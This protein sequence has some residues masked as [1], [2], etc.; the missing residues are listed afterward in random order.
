MEAIGPN[1]HGDPF[2]GHEHTLYD[3]SPGHVYAKSKRMVE[4]LVMKANNSVIMN[5]A[6]LYTCCQDP[7]E[8]TEKETN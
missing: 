8:F 5:G 7:L 4:Q 3:I 6:K 1:K 2:I